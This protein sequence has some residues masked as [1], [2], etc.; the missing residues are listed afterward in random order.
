MRDRYFSFLGRVLNKRR[1]VLTLFLVSLLL[2]L[3]AGGWL[4]SAVLIGSLL[5][6]LFAIGL[7][8]L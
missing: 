1:R 3:L 2:S 6:F 4:F 8:P 7:D 5:S